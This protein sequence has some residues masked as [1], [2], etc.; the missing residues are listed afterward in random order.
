MKHAE[1]RRDPW[2]TI[3]LHASNSVALKGVTAGTEKG[4]KAREVAMDGE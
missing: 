2:A 3:R 1:Y 4:A